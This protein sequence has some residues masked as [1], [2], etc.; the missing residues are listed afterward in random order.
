M[1]F[2]KRRKKKN[3]RSEGRNPAAYWD[4]VYGYYNEQETIDCNVGNYRKKNK[5]NKIKKIMG[6]EPCK[7][8]SFCNS[9]PTRNDIL[10][11]TIY[12]N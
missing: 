4:G 2:R 7:F 12:R 1:F 10:V 11:E 6:F 5:K 9:I 8:E 3:K